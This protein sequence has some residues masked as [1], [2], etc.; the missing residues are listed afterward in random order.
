M[1]ELTDQQKQWLGDFCNGTI[2][3][4]DFADLEAALLESAELRDMARTYFAMDSYLNAGTEGIVPAETDWQPSLA[5]QPKRFPVWAWIAVAAACILAGVAVYQAG[6]KPQPVEQIASVEPVPVVEPT[7]D[8]IAVIRNAADA[9]W[10]DEAELLLGDGSILSPGPLTLISGLA[11]IEF[12]NG[13][14]LILEGPVELEL[15]SL[16]RAICKRGKLRAHVP[17]GA[18]GFSVVSERFELVDLGT[19]FGISV[20]DDGEAKVEVFDGEVV[21]YEPDGKRA[22]DKAI[23]LLGGSGVA[24]NREGTVT[25][26]ESNPAEFTSQDQ[27]EQHQKRISERQAARWRRWIRQSRR[28]ERIVALYPFGEAAAQLRELSEERRHGVIVG[29]EWTSGR[30]QG[31]QALEFKRPSDRVRV[32]VPG[33]FDAATFIAWVRVDA[34]PG[35]RQGL[36]LTDGHKLGHVHWQ[37]GPKGELRFG[38]RIDPDNPGGQRASGSHSEPVF[39]PRRLGVWTF[40]CATYDRESGVVRQYVN[41]HRWS[42]DKIL[43]DQALKIGRGTIGNWS[44][45]VVAKQSSASPIR[46]FV[47]RIDGVSIWKT[48]FSDE[49]VLNAYRNTRP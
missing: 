13:V 41:G 20:S 3:P 44:E 18:E 31:K 28:D 16:D 10:G 45:P 21:L 8:G 11:Q 2:S 38:M 34:L 35:R 42:E 9:V 36:L 39:V 49:Q 5:P 46:N 48:A 30:H 43:Y 26:I 27:L 37:V 24:Y 33:E 4:E 40:V 15:V 25:K 7:D 23:R 29:C 6:N 19:E 47:G 14:R 22:E 12:Y 17:P 1:T 32:N